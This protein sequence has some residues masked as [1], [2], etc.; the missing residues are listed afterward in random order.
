MSVVNSC[1]V[2]GWKIKSIEFST[3]DGVPLAGEYKFDL[4][5]GQFAIAEGSSKVQVKVDN[6]PELVQNEAF[7][8]YMS[9]N[10]LELV[11]K[12]MQSNGSDRKGRRR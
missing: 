8:G 7:H 6:A 12:A 9:I 1:E 2:C 10:P 5:T 4:T 3:E 11:G